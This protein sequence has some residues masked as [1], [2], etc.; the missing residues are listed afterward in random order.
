MKTEFYQ[1]LK[2]ECIEKESRLCIGLDI[3]YDLYPKSINKTID[4][5]YDF[6][7]MIVDSTHEICASYK[8]NLGFFEQF[9]YKGY[10]LMEKVVDYIDNKAITIADGKR[11]DI[12]NSSKKYAKSIFNQIG[13]DSATISPYMGR[14]SITPFIDDSKFGAFVLCLTSNSGSNDLQKK[15]IN[16]NPMYMSVLNMLKDL[17]QD[18]IGIVVGATQE[19]EMRRIRSEAPLM[20]WL[21]PGIGKQGGNLEMSVKIGNQDGAIGIINV[22]RDILYHGDSTEKD[23]YLRTLFYHNKIKDFLN[24]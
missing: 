24:D 10:E 5:S 1:K 15:M 9:G 14:D 11:G 7:K 16:N 6:I 2:K 3:D 18:N 22:S 23:I 4:G 21:I 8:I 12:G 19:D 20:P 17:K 13:F